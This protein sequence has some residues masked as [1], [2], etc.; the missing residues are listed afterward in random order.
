MIRSGNWSNARR[1]LRPDGLMLAVFPA[2][3]TLQELRAALAG[4]ESAIRGGLSPRVLPMGDLRDLG[5]LLQRAGLALPVADSERHQVQ[6]RSMLHLM[7]DLRAMGE[8]NALYHRARAGLRRDVLA[9]AAARYPATGP[10]GSITATMELVTLTGWSPSK[11]QPR[12]LRPGSAERRLADALGGC[13][14]PF[15]SPAFR[16][17]VMIDLTGKMTT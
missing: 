1:A 11:T 8:T 4:A 17:R 10:D 6:Y 5:G 9:E 2:G 16:P 13:R 3:Q 7:R 14:N 12:P 15:G